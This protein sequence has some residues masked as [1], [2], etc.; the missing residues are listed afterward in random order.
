MR[1]AQDELAAARELACAEPA[2]TAEV[3]DLRRRVDQLTDELAVLLRPRDPHHRDNVLLEVWAVA[4]D[5]ESALFVADLADQYR[6]YARHHGWAVE[7][8]EE[9]RSELFGYRRVTLSISGRGGTWA[10]FEFE[11]GGHRIRR[12]PVVEPAEQPCTTGAEVLAYPQTARPERVSLNEADLRID[13]YCSRST[14]PAGNQQAVHLTHLPSGITA[15]SA[16]LTN[17]Y[18]NKRRAVEVLAARL[19]AVDAG[20]ARA[21]DFTRTRTATATAY[22]RSYDL[23]ANQITDHRVEHSVPG[24]FEPGTLDAFVDAL[25]AAE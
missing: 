1:E 19:R 15:Y 7:H 25:R 6:T 20:L 16:E 21:T 9:V 17:Q 12:F 11:T 23:V 13:L 4:D 18:S 10:A 22:I 3:T 8:L 2:F 24:P 5:E 14:R